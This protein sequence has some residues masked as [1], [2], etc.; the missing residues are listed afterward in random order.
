MYKNI[1]RFN[2]SQFT[3]YIIYYYYMI[4]KN[5]DNNNDNYSTK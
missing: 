1:K 2:Y 4:M 3:V 5:N